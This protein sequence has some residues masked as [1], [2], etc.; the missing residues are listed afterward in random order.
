MVDVRLFGL[1]GRLGDA[2]HAR[3][4]WDGKRAEAVQDVPGSGRSR[5]RAATYVAGVGR[6]SGV[7]L[8]ATSLMGLAL[9]SPPASF[10]TSQIPIRRTILDEFAGFVGSGFL[11]WT[12]NSLRHPNLY[13][14]F[15]RD[16]G[17]STLRVNRPG[18]QGFG[19]GIDGTTVVYEEGTRNLNRLVL[20]DTAARN[21][22][23]LPVT[24][25]P[26]SGMHPTISGSWILYAKG[27]RQKQTSVRLYNRATGETRQ[28][29]QIA[30]RGRRRF[31]YAGQVAGDRAVWGRVRPGRQDVFL[32]SL[33]T[34]K[35][36]RIPGPRGVRFQYDP[37]VTPAGTVFFERNRPCVRRCPKLNTPAMLAQLVAQPL[38]GRPRVLATLRKG[39]DGGYMYAAQEE[40]R[41]K[42]VYS[43]FRHLPHGYVSFSDIFALTVPG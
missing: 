24:D 11:G 3:K 38:G 1:V 7:V 9:T 6:A 26:S 22:A 20:Y 33:T 18:T 27:V 28:L 35:T 43:L 39:Q 31:V 16:P 2:V 34:R 19:G 15:L 41:V 23:R 13:N 29:G 40:E 21:Y 25:S 14:L 36:V 42:V 37:A 5:R 4:C 32:T 17:G 12:Q 10:A 8:L 30:A